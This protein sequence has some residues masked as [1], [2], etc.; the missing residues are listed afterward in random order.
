MSQNALSVWEP[1]RAISIPENATPSQMA[2]LAQQL[3]ERDVRSI[4]AAFESGSYEMVSTFVWTRASAS[5]KKQIATLGMDF[6]G[7]M[8]G[9][10][11]ITENSDPLTAIGDYEAISLAEDLGMINTTE[12]MR[13][14]MSLEIVGHFSDPEVALSESMMPEEATLLLRSCI[15]NILANP[16][17]EPP[18]QFAQLRKSLESKTYSESDG[19]VQGLVALPYFFLKTT[20]SV[21]LSLLKTAK[22]AQKEHAG[23]N[24]NVFIPAMWQSLRKPERWQVGQSYSELTNEGDRQASSVLKRALTTVQGFDYVPETL[25]SQTYTEVAHRLMQTHYAFNNFYNEPEAIRE[26]F[27]L[28]TTIPKPAFPLCMSAILCVRLGNRYGV[29]VAAQE[30][31]NAILSELRK[32]QWEYYLNECLPSDK[33]I[34]E[35]IASGGNTLERWKSLV[36]EFSLQNVPL[37]DKYVQRVLSGQASAA[38]TLRVRIR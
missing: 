24:C 30:P 4:A 1:N 34:L 8:L 36:E 21:L 26:L 10:Q 15:V 37:A 23:G 22:G 33:N 28:G 2:R 11:D 19:E 32:T 5:L 27:E 13:L 18:V 38:R 35:K 14:K 31:A 9:R 16:T 6:V 17:I 25:R 3:S 7:E 12:A 20:L 29:S